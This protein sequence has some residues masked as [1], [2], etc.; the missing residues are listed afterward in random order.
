MGKKASVGDSEHLFEQDSEIIVLWAMQ[1]KES[2]ALTLQVFIAS[3]DLGCFAFIW[4]SSGKW[5]FL[6]NCETEYARILSPSTS[7]VS[8]ARFTNHCKWNIK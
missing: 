3:T 6:L 5:Y 8:I 4:S 1:L 7:L 2:Q